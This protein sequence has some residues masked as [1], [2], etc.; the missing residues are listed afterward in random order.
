MVSIIRSHSDR[1]LK[2]NTT[3]RPRET[4]T[5]KSCWQAS[6]S[7]TLCA[8]NRFIASLVL[9]LTALSGQAFA[10][11]GGPFDMGSH[12]AN[13][14]RNS[15]YQGVLTLT[16][17]AGY[18]YFSPNADV[19]PDNSSSTTY[20]LKGSTLNRAIIYY[21][22]VTYLGSCFGTTDFEARTIGAAINASSEASTGGA[23]NNNGGQNNNTATS[24]TLN[25]SIYANIVAS[26]KSFTVNG[27]FIG[28]I[29][30]TAPLL[31]FNG[32][33]ELAFLSPNGADSINTLAY[34]SYSGLIGAII[35]F[36]GNSTVTNAD[37][38][39]YSTVFGGAQT[40][41]KDAL[42]DLKNNFLS[43]GGIDATYSEAKVVGIRVS[44]T[45]RYL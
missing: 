32:K 39:D 18:V 44:G 20:S 2:S 24:T 34:Q 29:T 43:S 40:A 11:V 31:R 3:I 21:Q 41:I 8:M 37:S 27:G 7:A 23:S 17:G 19:V 16:N 28:K 30:K 15:V 35:S 1:R 5:N 9:S 22:G 26:G 12:G 4:R 25:P 38:I 10:L 6:L 14:D 33:G 42:T 36:V 13:L 45:R